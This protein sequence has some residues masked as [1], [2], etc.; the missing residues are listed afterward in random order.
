MPMSDAT[1]QIG[2]GL[3]HPHY[4]EALNG[5][6]AVDFVEVHAEN[7]FAKGGATQAVLAEIGTRYPISIHG[8]AL[9]LASAVD[10]P[11]AYLQQLATLYQQ[12]NP[13]L[14]SDHLAQGWFNH[15]Q[16]VAHVGDL[17]AVAFDE[18]TLKQTIRQINQ[19]QEYLGRQLL[20]E[21]I[22][23]YID[24][25]TSHYRES[26]FLAQLIAQTGCGLLLDINNL[27]VNARNRQVNDIPFY[28]QQWLSDIPNHAIGEIH[29]A[30]YQEPIDHSPIIDDH[31]QPVSDT[32]WAAYAQVLKHCGGKPTLIEWD[33]NLPSWQTL[34]AE[35]NTARNI[36][37]KVLNHVD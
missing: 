19:T 15:N 10:V 28:I 17:L 26:E 33:T 25:S 12:V 9:A 35:A 30:G 14:V 4:A 1:I 2:V 7:F 34:V 36:A 8:T 5:E 20:I 3:R 6:A 23:N 11:N 32:V 18:R 13:I 31:S 27:V 22:A 16:Q 37:L 21:N 24:F 29:L